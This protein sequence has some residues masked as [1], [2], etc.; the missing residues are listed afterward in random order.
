[1][2][3]NVDEIKK[4]TQMI[5]DMQRDIEDQERLTLRQN[6]HHRALVH[7]MMPILTSTFK[8]NSYVRYGGYQRVTC[9]TF[10]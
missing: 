8:D 1:M 10:S 6:K 9:A 7:F 5:A 3:L 2:G 4:Y